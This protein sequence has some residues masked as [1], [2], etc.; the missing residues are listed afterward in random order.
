[1]QHKANGLV[2]TDRIRPRIKEHRAHA[3]RPRVRFGIVHQCPASAR[4]SDCFVNDDVVDMQVWAAHQRVHRPHSEN[5]YKPAFA[6]STNKLV[7]AV[8][9]ALDPAQELVLVEMR[10]QL[11]DERENP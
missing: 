10:A 8:A 9:L 11:R 7:T 2:E 4:L 6:E 5:A 1:M 3:A